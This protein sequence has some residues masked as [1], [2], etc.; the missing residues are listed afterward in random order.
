MTC[1]D[2]QDDRMTTPQDPRPNFLHA[3]AIATALIGG[4]RDDQLD[5]PT[6]CDEFAVRDLLGHLV[7]VMERAIVI[8]SLGDPNEAPRLIDLDGRSTLTEWLSRAGRAAGI[9]A[10]DKLLGTIVTLPFAKLPGAAAMAIYASELTVHSWDLATAT[11]QQVTWNDGVCR[12]SLQAMQMA[13][14][15]DMV[16]DAEL[17]FGAVVTVPDTAPIIDQLVGWNGRQP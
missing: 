15:A 2:W 16:R 11:G 4:V 9:W 13:L 12:A 7:A 17:P 14:P 5:L 1:L 8:G 3:T 6:P 10:D